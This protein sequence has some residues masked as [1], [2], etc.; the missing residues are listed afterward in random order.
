VGLFSDEIRRNIWLPDL[1]EAL[2][3]DDRAES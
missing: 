1:T 3:G 2:V